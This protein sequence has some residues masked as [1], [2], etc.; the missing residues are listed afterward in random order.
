[1]LASL[2]ISDIPIAYYPPVGP[3][4]EFFVTYDAKE[5]NQPS[6]INF[7]NFGP[8]WNFSWISTI[9]FDG[10]L[11]ASV[12]LGTGGTEVYMNTNGDPSTPPTYNADPKA[13]TVMV[14][15]NVSDYERRSQDGSKMVFALADSSGRLYVTEI[16][17]AQGNKVTLNY[18]A[19]FRL[20]NIQDAIGQFST[21]S[22]GSNTVGATL[23]YNITQITG[24]VRSASF[25]YTGSGQLSSITDE[26]GLTSS[27][28]YDT[29]DFIT[30]LATPY[31]STQFT[32]T[33]SIDG[34]V[35]TTSGRGT[36]RRS[37]ARRSVV[38]SAFVADAE[39]VSPPGW[40]DNSL[41][42]YRNSFFWDR[43]AMH[44]AWAIT[45]RRKCSTSCTMSPRG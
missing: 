3:A 34:N 41:L 6:T 18:D 33:L 39:P 4:I 1:M 45:P 40:V 31:G 26:I 27:F 11:N 21:F 23:F 36:R 17:D 44:D 5:A 29:N 7:S 10:A 22:Y 8:L 24:L 32:H 37:A 19:N 42:E 2:N 30:T 38:T 14:Q 43:K 9:T 13:Q 25:S 35:E 28:A 20:V 16:W 12:A 15:V